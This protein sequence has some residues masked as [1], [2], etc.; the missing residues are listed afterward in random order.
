MSGASVH[1]SQLLE[2]ALYYLN[3]NQMTTEKRN[4]HTMNL[5][6]MSSL[7]IV[8]AMNTEDAKIPQAINPLLPRIAQ[9]VDW[10]IQALQQGGRIFYM[11]AGTSGRLGVLLPLAFPL[12]WSWVLSPVARALSSRP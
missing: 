1:R 9:A 8:T 4:Q 6:A 5:D 11:G 12:I 10:A 7:E 2:G 3:L